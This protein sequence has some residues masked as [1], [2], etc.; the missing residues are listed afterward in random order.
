MPTTPNQS[1]SVPSVYATLLDATVVAGVAT[2]V[3]H[4]GVTYPA[5]RVVIGSIGAAG[6]TLTRPDGTA[7]VM[8]S[9][10]CLAFGGI[11]NRQCIA[12]QSANSTDVGVEY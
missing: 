7:V 4:A 5:R 8:S 3:T 6:I 1:D 11:I 9:A 12:V 2:T 10:Q